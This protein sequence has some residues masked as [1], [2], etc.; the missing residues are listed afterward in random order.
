MV[1]FKNN[2]IKFPR[3]FNDFST[4][5]ILINELTNDKLELDFVDRS[6]S[7]RYYLIDLS[8]LTLRNGSY[9]YEIGK[10]IGLMQV[11]DYIAPSTEYKETKINVVY[12]R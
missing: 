1:Y 4:K 2:L 11:G 8:N 5:M 3:H 7:D 10:D 6:D 12:E 9:R